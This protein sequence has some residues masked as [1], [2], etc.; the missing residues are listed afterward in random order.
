MITC[1]SYLTDYVVGTVLLV[2]NIDKDYRLCGIVVRFW[3]TFSTIDLDQDQV[4]LHDYLHRKYGVRQDVL[5][6]NHY[7]PLST[8]ETCQAHLL[9][10]AVKINHK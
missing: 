2:L 1:V 6:A 8:I 10:S 5:F 7:L 9:V 4:L 3:N